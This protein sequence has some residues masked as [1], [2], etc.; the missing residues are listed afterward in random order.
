MTKILD[1]GYEIINEAFDANKINYVSPL[2]AYPQRYYLLDEANINTSLNT[3]SGTSLAEILKKKADINA[4]VNV[5]LK[6]FE[7]NVSVKAFKDIIHNIKIKQNNLIL[8]ITD[9]GFGISQVLPILVQGFMSSKRSLTIIEQPEI[10]LHPKMQADLADLFIDIINESKNDKDKISRTLIIETHS[11]YILK[12]L[13]RRV[14]EGKVRSQDIAIYFIEPRTKNK[15]SAVIKKVKMSSRGE[16]EWPE[17]FYITSY[18]DDI[19]YFK[20]ISQ[21]ITK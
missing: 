18:E 11:E 14:S 15:S 12:R 1:S 6:K 10:H 20:N 7:I 9:V 4:K 21:E 17:D 2:R 5:W 19:E 3:Q 13:R 16:F 8:D